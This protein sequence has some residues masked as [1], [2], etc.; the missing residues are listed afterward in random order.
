MRFAKPSLQSPPAMHPFQ[1][2][3]FCNAP[4]A[5]SFPNTTFAKLLLESPQCKQPLCKAQHFTLWDFTTTPRLVQAGGGGQLWPHSSAQ[6]GHTAPFMKPDRI[7]P[8]VSCLPAALAEARSAQQTLLC[9]NLINRGGEDESAGYKYLLLP[10]GE[11][12]SGPTASPRCDVVH[13]GDA[14]WWHLAL[15]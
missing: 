8:F 5:N 4:F 11:G 15:C 10:G 6:P 12:T 2:P 1:S 14:W 7:K 9:A 3:P 13:G